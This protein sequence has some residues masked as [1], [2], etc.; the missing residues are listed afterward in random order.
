MS[1][2]TP[3]RSN[4]QYR[5]LLGIGT[6]LLMVV[7]MVAASPASQAAGGTPVVGN[8]LATTDL[9]APGA[10]AAI[11]ANL[12]IPGGSGITGISNV[13]F[14]GANNQAGSI[15][16]VDPNIVSFNDG[17]I[18]SSGNIADVVGP[19]K[20]DSTTTYQG[21]VGD[22]DL[23][24]LIKDTQTVWPATYDATSLSFDFTAPAGAHD[25]YFTYVFGSDEY[26]EWVNLY[27]DVFGL[28]V[29]GQNC[30][31]AP[32]ATNTGTVPVSIDTINSAVN[33]N[34][35]RDNAFMYGS[36][37]LNFESDGLSVEMVCHATINP[38]LNHIKFAIAD[39][40]DGVLDSIVIIKSGSFSTTP[41]ESCNNKVDDDGDNA[42]DMD[43]TYCTTT[44][45]AAPPGTSTLPVDP[46]TNLP[47]PV[48]DVPTEFGPSAISTPPFT[49]N[50][51]SPILLDGNLKGWK[52]INAAAPGEPYTVSTA[53]T[54]TGINGTT[55]TCAV[56][57]SGAIPHA[58]GTTT[59][60]L[61]SA[62][63]SQEG[64]YVARLEGT[65]SEGGNDISYDI[66]F[67][68]HNAPP[69]VSV[70]GT[71]PVSIETGVAFDFVANV[72]DPGGDATTCKVNWGDGSSTSVMTVV[73]DVCQA[74]HTYS[75]VPDIGTALIAVIATDSANATA[76][77]LSPM[78]VSLSSN[79]VVP[80]A[81]TT[82]AGVSGDGSVALSWVAPTFDGGDA[83]DLYSVT[84]S[85]T[86]GGAY[87]D[88]SA[89][90]VSIAALTCTATGLINGTTYFFKVIAHNAAG[91]SVESAASSGVI[92]AGPQ[93]PL[94]I[95][96]TTLSV[97]A[98][99]TVTIS[100]SG[101]SGSGGYSY[102]TSSA[103]CAVS[104]AGVLSSS[105]PTSC[106][107]TAT[108]AA[109]TGY[110][111]VTSAP[112]TFTFVGLNQATVT[113]SNATKSGASTATFTLTATGG[114]G[115]GVY[116]FAVTGTGCVIGGASFNILSK[117]GGAGTCSVIATRAASGNYASK[118][119]AAVVFTFTTVAQAA[120]T[121]SNATAA[122]IAPA[123]TAI[124][125]TT[126]GG[127]GTGAI[128]IASATAGCS[129]VGMT[130]NRSSATGTCAVIATK[131]G[132]NT[133]SATSSASATFT[134]TA[135]AQTTLVIA[136]T[137]VSSTAGTPIT[138]SATGGSGSGALT[139]TTTGT[140]CSIAT[141]SLNATAA[142][143]CVVTAKMA[144]SGIYAA[145]TSATKS[146]VFALATQTPL[147]IS[148]ATLTG[149][150]GTAIAL[151]ST[152]GSG[153]GA[154]TY[155][156]T[157]TGCTIATANLNATTSATCVVTAKKAANGIYAAATSATQ[158]FT[159][160]KASQAA[161]LISNAT[162]TGA[163]GTAGIT[164]T[165]TGGSG[166]GAVTYTVTGTVCKIAAAKL[167]VATSVTPGTPVTCTVT[168]SK[169]ASG[170]YNVIA[171]LAKVFTFN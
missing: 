72:V 40:S 33:S 6:A 43:D 141:T 49:G 171:S 151:T 89:S 62:V 113:V 128:T 76:A 95:T 93:S 166:T 99:T 3:A 11:L 35:F 118:A 20:S 8:A 134:F 31:V 84:Q 145:A 124:T 77:A 2:N 38:G 32:D 112:V 98:G 79:I 133:Y 48:Q 7:S 104:S 25:L 92:P 105:F 159:F 170:I 42:V 14:V 150:A 146:F 96:N 94:V 142:A 5:R 10:S 83:I 101:G 154:L 75:K 46:T 9:S 103:N 59:I 44:T 52:A 47:V 16:L 121:I 108:R 68:V 30:A 86:L 130:I 56:Y 26:L 164:L 70:D 71:T 17:V 111:A 36:N 53:W 143:T 87:V 153:A 144:A 24:Q 91:W 63:C 163:K 85:T 160:V 54:V 109:S 12:L 139:F 82:L 126:A 117:T 140:G 15:H 45:V 41:I 137:V 129:V 127:S 19:N 27:N 148:N 123:G 73:N 165:T 66:D 64:E 167:T 22:T 90:C 116:S 138:L 23:D 114:T 61:A 169:A 102:N 131:A 74:S 100:K 37:P 157:G 50:E 57:P 65:D 106:T 21:N 13:S 55:G 155:T 147:V 162:L 69:V 132:D 161:L 122:K 158:T 81:P 67:F 125:V 29:N 80:D 58:Y 78:E 88:S 51:G 34:L 107:V 149:T 168:A 115:S 135:A 4:R 119:S 18:M 60:E 136:N 1:T 28:F 156:V 152:G 110:L 39:T 97:N 120:L